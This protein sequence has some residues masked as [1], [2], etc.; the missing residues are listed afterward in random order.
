MD[1]QDIE[2]IKDRIA[3]LLR[4]AADAS[5]PNEAAIAAQRARALM[6]K[7]QLDSFDIGNRMK[8]DFV[9]EDVSR[10][11]AAV[12]QYLSLFAT[13]VA[14][15]NDVQSRFRYGP[16]THRQGGK[17]DNAKTGGYCIMFQG[18]KSDVQ[19]AN[20]MFN[21][22]CETVNRLCKEY[23]NEKGFARYSVRVGGQFKH[24]AFE[25][26][27]RRLNELTKDR[28]AITSACGTSL[29][30]FKSAAVEAKF[31]KVNY[32]LID[33]AEVTDRSDA[34]ARAKGRE[35]GASIEIIK[36]L[37]EEENEQAES[38]VRRLAK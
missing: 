7:H 38:Q 32:K 37:E 5:S 11:Y 26:I 30:L 28:D 33:R 1:F 2:K 17:G 21:Y 14:K 4:M 10:F 35:K 24:G 34:D 31:G 8:D 29:V 27:E 23:M 18:Y 36:S 22:L 3:K 13:A 25:V 12:P 16:V 9:S 15:Y 6:D 20:Q 19:L